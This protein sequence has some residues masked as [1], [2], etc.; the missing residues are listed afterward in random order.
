MRGGMEVGANFLAVL[1]KAVMGGSE[2]WSQFFNSLTF[3]THSCS[4]VC[5]SPHTR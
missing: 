2:V 1:A 5:I 4:Q 3:F